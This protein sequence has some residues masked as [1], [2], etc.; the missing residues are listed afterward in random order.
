MIQRPGGIVPH[1]LTAQKAAATGGTGD[2]ERRQTVP[3]LVKNLVA[4]LLTGSGG[5]IP[6]PAP[7]LHGVLTGN[8]LAGVAGQQIGVGCK[9]GGLV[10]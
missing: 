3:P 10:W 7:V 5:E 8:R 4:D 9:G 6:V 2:T 1:R